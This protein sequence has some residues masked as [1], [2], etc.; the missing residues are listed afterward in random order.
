MSIS[1]LG[2]RIP[3]ATQAGLRT[4]RLTVRANYVPDYS[5]P[6][7]SQY[8]GP[9]RDLDDSPSRVPIKKFWYVLIC[10]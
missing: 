1:T 8:R 5:S 9:G 3:F 6:D 2:M 10:C 4:R 7:P